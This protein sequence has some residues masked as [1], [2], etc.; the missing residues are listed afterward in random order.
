MLDYRE[1]TRLWD[2]K[3]GAAS[4]RSLGPLQGDN[5]SVELRMQRRGWGLTQ[6]HGRK[7][8]TEWGRLATENVLSGDLEDGSLTKDFVLCGIQWLPS[9][10]SL[11]V[12]FSMERHL[13]ILG[14]CWEHLSFWLPT[15]ISDL[16]NCVVTYVCFL[17]SKFV[18]L[19]YT[20]Q[21]NTNSLRY[22]MKPKCLHFT[23][24]ETEAQPGWSPCPRSACVW[25]G[26]DLN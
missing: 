13:C 24:G 22:T 17:T 23:E 8:G 7:L 3:W 10:W 5:I 6:Q 1:Q 9:T 19:C 25:Q 12:L 15:G 2:G 18:A 16:Q 20:T 26:K 21:I 11:S 4:A 14:H